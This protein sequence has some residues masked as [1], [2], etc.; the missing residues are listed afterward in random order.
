M[1]LSTLVA[2]SIFKTWTVIFW[3]LSH[4]EKLWQMNDE[5][6]GRNENK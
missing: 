6:H 4:I 2:V 3:C 5:I 1:L